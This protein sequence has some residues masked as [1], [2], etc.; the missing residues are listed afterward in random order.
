MFHIFNV[1]KIY[2]FCISDFLRFDLF[3]VYCNSIGGQ[4]FI[5]EIRHNRTIK[6][7]TVRGKMCWIVGYNEFKIMNQF[8]VGLLATLAQ[9][10]L[11]TFFSNQSCS[12]HFSIHKTIN[13]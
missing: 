8:I 12:T 13:Y 1:V 10:K 9:I 3:G 5:E 11:E 7:S 6:V 4:H 2:G